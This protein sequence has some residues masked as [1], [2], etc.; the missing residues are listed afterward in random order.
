[1]D[2]FLH[3]RWRVAGL[4]PVVNGSDGGSGIDPRK[5][6]WQEGSNLVAR[7]FFPTGIG[8]ETAVTG[9]TG[10]DRFRYRPV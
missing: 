10:P 8:L 6:R 3:V 1:M 2:E 4:R 7:F 5:R 9:V